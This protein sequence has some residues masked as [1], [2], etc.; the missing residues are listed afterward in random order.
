VGIEAFRL[1]RFGLAALGVAIAS[2]L[3]AESCG[4]G[5]LRRWLVVDRLL[6]AG[7]LHWR[8]LF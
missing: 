1:V 2:D 6:R 4:P 3:A 8:L 5:R 7:L